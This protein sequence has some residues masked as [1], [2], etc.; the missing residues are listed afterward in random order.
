MNYKLYKGLTNKEVYENGR[1]Y[2]TNTFVKNKKNTFFSLFIE[3][4]NDPI[5]KILLIALAVKIIFLFKDSNIYETLGILVAVFLAS[6]ISTISEYG[7]E[8]AFEKL[9][10]EN[11]K[12]K[13]KVIR[14]SKILEIDIEEIVVN[15]IILISSGDKVPAD[16]IV[17]DGTAAI[18]SSLLTGE[19]K[20]KYVY[21]NERVY[22]GSISL[23]GEILIK[24]TAVGKNTFYGSI[25]NAIQEKSEESPL[26]KRLKVLATFISK[27]GYIS[28]FLV[29]IA[30][31]FNVICIQNNFESDK[32]FSL[33][34]NFHLL[35]PHLIYALT[36]GV[37]IIV[38]A[39]PEGLPMMITLVLSS[40]MKRML[41]SHVLVRKLVG[42]ET[43]GSLNILFVDK[44]GTITNGI[45]ETSFFVDANFN[46]YKTIHDIRD[47]KFKEVVN[48]SCLYNNSS[49]YSDGKV[50]G[51]NSTDRAILSF[52]YNDESYKIFNSIKF[53][54]K[55]KYSA[56]KLNYKNM[57]FF[58]GAAE[59]LLEK[60][61][62]YYDE[63]LN[64]KII[65]NLLEI[66]NKINDV[67]KEGYR[68]LALCTSYTMEI[69]NMTL[70]GFLL[71]KDEVR[72]NAYKGLELT[73]KAGI[74]TVMITGDSKDTAYAIGKELNMVNSEDEILTSEDLSKLSDEKIKKMIPHLKIVSRA[75]PE[76]KY[77][78]V[79]LSQELNM[80]VGMTGDGVNDAPALKKAD[81]GF[82]MGNGTEVA[83]EVS[84]IVILNNDLLSI[85]NAILYGRTIFKSIR[86]FIIFQLTIN[87]CAIILSV[88]GPFI[89]I[90]EPITV[91]QMLWINMVMDTLAG[92]AFSFEP[93]LEE[94]M[95]E[96]P[97]EKSTP[98]LNKYMLN[99]IIVTG[100]YSAILCI[101]FLKLPFF[102]NFF[103]FDYTDKY[104]MTAFFGLFIFL[105]IFNSFNARTYRINVLSNIFK[106][107]P[108][109]IV[110]SLVV[111]IQVLIIYYGGAI[112]R[113]TGLTL[114]EFEVMIILAFS[115]IPIDFVRKIILK[116]L[117][118][119]RGV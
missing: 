16:G 79:K 81:V 12:I 117:G 4:L 35:A 116:K 115:I 109:I 45:L 99:Q 5:I 30:Y 106:N 61:A 31:L 41:K 25:S 38:L 69:S 51:G 56:V 88:I 85:T 40:N 80:V 102:K 112:F 21:K 105:A 78:L 95:E 91:M 89:G 47:D 58:K 43:A 63:K 53:D 60:C 14:N 22:K 68:V 113:T 15:D 57:C 64:K 55:K 114:Y 97:K 34:N 93:A 118:I 17:L 119:E 6:F 52:T 23:E 108:F 39:V 82:S 100:I 111:L 65:K 83:K 94:Y 9:E 96:P 48:L 92:L 72:K 84:D 42:I 10:E 18:D 110:I 76:D 71:L 32:I 70:V 67:M 59:I 13:S 37:T 2:G 24:I 98:I 73:R 46:K 49:Y 3:S 107:P 75:L 90:V 7:S 33:L 101:M 87:F 1:K 86:K 103:R 11:S 54:S 74:Q 19:S 26:K 20:E 77:K 44:T 36:L 66:K 50:V 28:A 62:Y 29:M 104:L 8:K 27:I